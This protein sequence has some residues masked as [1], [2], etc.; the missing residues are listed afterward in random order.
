MPLIHGVSGWGEEFCAYRD[1]GASQTELLIVG[2]SLAPPVQNSVT[3]QGLRVWIP[4]RQKTFLDL[5]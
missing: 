2:E 3:W 5:L 4:L 1:E